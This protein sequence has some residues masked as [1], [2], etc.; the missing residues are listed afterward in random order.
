MQDYFCSI[1]QHWTREEYGKAQYDA[2]DV[3]VGQVICFF[4]ARL[5]YKEEAAEEVSLA[6]V[7]WLDTYKQPASEGFVPAKLSWWAA[8]ARGPD[9]CVFGRLCGGQALWHQ[10][11]VQ[12][13][14]ALV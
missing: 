11:A 5:R 10:E 8:A 2:D 14:A 4:T 13:R 6:F 7:M 1:P 3:D 12:T 9:R